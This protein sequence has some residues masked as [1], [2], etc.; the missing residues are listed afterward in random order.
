MSTD[1]H[2]KLITE[3][4]NNAGLSTEEKP[5]GEL[6][7][8]LVVFGPDKHRICCTMNRTEADVIRFFY[9]CRVRGLLNGRETILGVH[10][11]TT[12]VRQMICF[13]L[14]FLVYREQTDRWVSRKGDMRYWMKK[15][16]KIAPLS[17]TIAIR[18]HMVLTRWPQTT[19]EIHAA[20]PK[21]VTKPY[22]KQ[23]SPILRRLLSDPNPK[24]VKLKKRS[25]SNKVQYCHILW[26]SRF[27]WKPPSTVTTSDLLEPISLS[28]PIHRAF[29]EEPN[30]MKEV[31]AK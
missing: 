7:A 30:E 13:I 3:Y 2:R 24:I 23:I 18:R 27:G 11:E 19:I 9:Q 4:C 31:L 20:L 16:K 21:N 10:K 28:Q 1:Y 29:H 5:D 25:K 26:A 12:K 6:L 8:A 17:T 22:L 15:E 14:D